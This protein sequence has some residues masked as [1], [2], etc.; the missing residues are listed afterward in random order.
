MFTKIYYKTK[1]ILI[2]ILNIFKYIITFII[3]FIFVFFLQDIFKF[4]DDIGFSLALIMATSLFLLLL[5]R[6]K[7]SPFKYLKIHKVNLKTILQLICFTIILVPVDLGIIALLRQTITTNVSTETQLYF[8]SVLHL[9]I[10]APISEEIFFRGILFQKL[11]EIMPLFLSLIIQGFIFG[12]SHGA[13]SCHLIQSIVAGL[14]GILYALVYNYKKNLTIPILL[15]S[16]YNS[17][18]VILN[19]LFPN[20]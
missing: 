6:E 16:F 8:W 17:F 10:L 18:L 4:N 19:L 13:L 20:F 12:I 9:V 2:F 1:E 3:S 14:S 7:K 15:H 11:K 5:K